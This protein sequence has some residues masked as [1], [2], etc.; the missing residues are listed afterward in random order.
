MHRC[1]RKITLAKENAQIL[2]HATKRG[3]HSSQNPEFWEWGPRFVA[4]F[5]LRAPSR[6]EGVW[7]NPVGYNQ[8]LK[9]LLTVVI[10]FRPFV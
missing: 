3:L 5:K 8:T 7:D 4:R 9:S 2:K 10:I 6:V 1:Y